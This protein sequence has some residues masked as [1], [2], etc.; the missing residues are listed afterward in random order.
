MPQFDPNK[1][2]R[3]IYFYRAVPRDTDGAQG[4]ELDRAAIATCIEGLKGKPDFYLDQGND[5]ITAATLVR[6]AA[7]QRITLYAIRRRDL[8]STDSG[9]GTFSILPLKEKEGLAEAI[10]IGLYPN[11][12]VVAEFFFYGPRIGRFQDFL[13]ERCGLDVELRNLVRGDVISQALK[14]TE[15]RA[16]RIKV[17]PSD[18]TLQAV[19]GLGLGGA[20]DAAKKYH[21]GYSVDLTLR[22]DRGDMSFTDRVR[23]FLKQSR[24]QDL[25]EILDAAEVTARNPATNELEDINLLSDKVVR[26]AIIERQSERS[27]ALDADSAFAAIDKVYNDLKNDLPA[28]GLLVGA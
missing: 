7:P 2:E 16:M 18:T 28:D 26:I 22:A 20:I 4:F 19:K 11:S 9:T 21:A 6:K 12:L 23:D 3:K 14:A 13:N 8:P 17:H 1:A 10:H 24:T 27:R 25:S 5:R 15:I